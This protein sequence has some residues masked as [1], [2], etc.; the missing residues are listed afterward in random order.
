[1]DT[2]TLSYGG[3]KM[4]KLIV[5]GI[6]VSMVSI[7]V[8]FNVSHAWEIAMCEHLVYDPEYFNLSDQIY[9]LAGASRNNDTD[10]I[11][12]QWIDSQGNDNNAVLNNCDAVGCNLQT[13]AV[14]GCN[15]ILGNVDSNTISDWRNL[16]FNFFY[17]DSFV[18]SISD[19]QFSIL[20]IPE[21]V[22]N[23]SAKTIIWKNVENA[24]FYLVRILDGLNVDNDI[25]F[26]SEKLTTNHYT[27]PE[28][29]HD[30]LQSNIVYV[31]ARQ[32][33]DGTISER[34]VNTSIYVTKMTSNES[35]GKCATLE[36]NLDIQMP[37]IDVFGT[38]F[39]IYLERY[40]NPNDP[41]GYYWKLRLQ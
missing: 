18:D 36:D 27:F 32:T 33:T 16:T 40:T 13:C 11:E 31:E 30:I 5:K 39:P 17:N 29:V 34:P 10:V 3:G 9:I 22:G 37:C 20:P 15:Q 2:P 7:L 21:A 14:V 35:T 8:C 23:F 4:K 6:L 1:M 12:V 28:S 26:E 25:I 41:S 19:S 38:Q 24:S